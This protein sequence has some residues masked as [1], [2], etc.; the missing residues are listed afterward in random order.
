LKRIIFWDRK[1]ACSAF[2]IAIIMFASSVICFGSDTG[3]ERQQLS[4]YEKWEALGK[5]AAD[6]SLNLI[7]KVAVAPHSGNLIVLTNAGYAEVNGLPKHL[8]QRLAMALLTNSAPIFGILSAW[9]NPK[10]S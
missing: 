8:A 9:K 6:V 3:I 7:K 10:T 2:A 4:A 5:Y 1:N